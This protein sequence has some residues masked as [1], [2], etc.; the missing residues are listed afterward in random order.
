RSGS[1]VADCARIAVI[2]RHRGTGR[3]GLGLVSGFNL[4]QGAIA[5]TVAHDAHNIMVLGSMAQNGASDMAI[6]IE[7]LNEIGGGQVAVLDGQVIAVV[8]LIIG[9]LIST[10]RAT[11]IAAELENLEAQAHSSLGITLPAPF[12]VLSFLGLSVIPEL[13]I[14]D[15]GLIDVV[16]FTKTTLTN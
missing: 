15:L 6:A 14:T 5:S 16:S 3:F 11:E 1:Q 9:G 12:M 13:R 10:K 2:E 8:P 7:T 4:T